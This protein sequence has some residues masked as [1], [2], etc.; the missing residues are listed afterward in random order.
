MKT[1]DSSG[2]IE[3]AGDTGGLTQQQPVP[4]CERPT[5]PSSQAT[6][7]RLSYFLLCLE[8]L[9]AGIIG[10]DLLLFGKEIHKNVSISEFSRVSLAT[11]RQSP[12]TDDC[13]GSSLDTPKPNRPFR[14]HFTSVGSFSVSR[15]QFSNDFFF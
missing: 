12:M 15:I 14:S 2:F 5:T 7:A 10:L 4:G 13:R 8:V 6:S 11:Q 9:S 1:V 3:E